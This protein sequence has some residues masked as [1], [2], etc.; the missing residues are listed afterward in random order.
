M[1]EMFKNNAIS[2]I[3]TKARLQ[4]FY[5]YS[6]SKKFV[7]KI[8]GSPFEA[9]FLNFISCF[10]SWDTLSQ[11]SISQKNK[12]VFHHFFQQ[13]YAIICQI[14]KKLPPVR[15]ELTTPGLQDQCS[16]TEL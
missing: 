15:F 7:E 11:F 6:H 4:T 8:F 13:N 3:L 1:Y 2:Y 9:Y 12:K 5:H 16:A 14:L 10:I